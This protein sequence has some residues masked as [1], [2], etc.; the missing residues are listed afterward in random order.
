MQ[1]I[2]GTSVSTQNPI[3]AQ[4]KSV[5]YLNSSISG[6]VPSSFSAYDERSLSAISSGA[7]VGQTVSLKLTRVGNTVTVSLNKFTAANASAANPI[8]Y[9]SALPVSFIPASDK[10]VMC[11]VNLNGVSQLGACRVFASNGNIVIYSDAQSQGFVN[12]QLCGYENICFSY[13]L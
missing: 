13:V 12:G 5:T 1:Y 10:Y 3:D 4:V 6:Y 9:A 7:I 8:I 11:V 2:N